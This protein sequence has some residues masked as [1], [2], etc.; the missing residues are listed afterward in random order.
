MIILVS[1]LVVTAYAAAALADCTGRIAV[2]P[3]PMKL[4][5]TSGNFALKH[6]TAIYVQSSSAEIKNIANYLADR[7]RP[8]TGLSLVVLEQAKAMEGDIKNNAEW[9]KQ[10]IVCY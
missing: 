6:K 3:K 2:I 8:A 4:E 5:Q 9:K 1:L 7:L 10:V